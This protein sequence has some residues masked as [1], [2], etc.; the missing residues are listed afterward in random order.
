MS[1]EINFTVSLAV[2]KNGSGSA[3]CSATGT[4][5][6]TGSEYAGIVQTLSTTEAAVNIG[7]CDQL[8]AIMIKNQPFK[9]DGSDNPDNVILGLANPIVTPIATIPPGKAIILWGAP[10]TI[11]A[12][13][14]AATPD[15]FIVPVE[16]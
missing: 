11:Y 2:A 4:A 6:L 16:T 13:S 14:S 9:P 1:Q 8:Q 12:K 3:A 10:T 5:D 15:I 7:G